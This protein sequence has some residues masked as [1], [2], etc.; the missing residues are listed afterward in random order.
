L[1]W[2]LE[3]GRWQGDNRRKGELPHYWKGRTEWAGW[4]EG[5]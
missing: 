3:K 2:E 4:E 5:G 1:W